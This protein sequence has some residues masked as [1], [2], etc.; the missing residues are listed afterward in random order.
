MILRKPYAF[1]I[2]YFKLI[3]F[4]LAGLAIYLAYKTFDIINFF[5]EYIS[6]NY[7]GN[8]Y[9]GFYNSYINPFVY[10]IVI[11]VLL[12][13]IGI[14]LLFRYKKKPS[15]FYITSIVYYIIL[16]IFFVFIKD[17]M[18]TIE[19]TTITAETSRFYRDLS[20]IAFLPQVILIIIFIFRGLGF[21]IKKFN[22][23]DDLKEIQIEEQDNEE[24]EIVLKKDDVKLRRNI[25]R[26][27][28]EFK[29]YV[30]ENKFIFSCICIVIF[31]II[32]FFIFKAFPE[33]IDRD[34]NQGETFNIENISYKIE[35]SIVTNLDYNGKK[36]SED[37]YYVVVKMFIENKSQEDLKLDYNN[38]RLIIED[39]YKYPIKDKG[40]HFVDYA[41]DYYSE[42]LKGSSSG[43]Y[44]MV[45]VIEKTELR[46][47]Y[48]IKIYSG[49]TMSDNILVGKHSYV[50]IS[51]PVVNKVSKSSSVKLDEV[52]SFS[53]SYLKNTSL[54]L[55]N[56]KFTDR[57]VYDY[58]Q[59]TKYSCNTYKD[60]VSVNYMKRD[61]T[62]IVLDYSFEIDSTV[63]FHKYSSSIN[64]F[65]KS[66][67]KLRYLENKQMVE[68]SISN[69]TPSLLKDKLVFETTNKILTSEEIEIIFTIRNKEYSVKIK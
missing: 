69:V 41:E 45:Y 28:R 68:T 35:D 66:F 51:P 2:K 15:T 40:I 26:F 62:L 56:V 14:F 4:I 47:N 16:I 6:N 29:Y 20:L 67:T 8:Y 55:A 49:N 25:N 13:L 27:I 10:L 9:E 3:N 22:F 21:N 33:I 61:T 24:I 19:G 12:G 11:I 52:L 1:L 31:G 50:T 60:I 48:K 57:Y 63:P 36:I 43:T 39:T 42:I 34:Y 38:F 7:T 54:K 23:D 65:I 64:G 17:I 5:N 53:D 44:S 18:V 46:K 59:C 58:E 37:K 32:V 30:K